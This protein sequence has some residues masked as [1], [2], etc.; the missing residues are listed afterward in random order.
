MK[1]KLVSALLVLTMGLSL[2][3]CGQT[4]EKEVSEENKPEVSKSEEKTSAAESS[5]EEP[6]ELDPY[7]VTYWIYCADSEDAEM[8]DEAFNERL[9]ELLPNTTVE[10]VRVASSE[11]RD[12]WNKALASGEKIDIGWSAN[13]VNPVADDINMGVVNP[14]NDVLA[15]YG[16]GIIEAIGGQGVVGLHTYSDGNCYFVPCWQGLAGQRIKAFYPVALAA[17]GAAKD[18]SDLVS[19]YAEQAALF[20]K[21]GYSTYFDECVKQLTEYVESRNLGTVKV[22]E[23]PVWE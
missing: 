1:R 14:L 13:W 18:A 4:G 10:F 23:N 5:E 19:V 9:A 16:Q 6:E 11:Y 20:E 7:T 15:E 17:M 12:R 8:V 21:A 2:I 22:I 3:G